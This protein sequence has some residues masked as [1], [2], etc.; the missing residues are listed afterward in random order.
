MV[1]EFSQVTIRA[2]SLADVS[3]L[4]PMIEKICALHQAWDSAKYGFLPEPGKHY[5]GWLRSQIEDDLSLILAAETQSELVG[6]LIATEEQKIPIYQLQA[7]GFVHDL[8]VEPAYRQQGIAQRLVQ[9]TIDHFR[10]IGVEQIR[11]DVATANQSAAALFQ[12]CGFRP[13]TQEMLIVLK[14]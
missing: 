11:L 13:S 5:E 3:A 2:A 14:D 12:A 8:W 9:R 4:L 1:L 10:Q 6:F 7:F